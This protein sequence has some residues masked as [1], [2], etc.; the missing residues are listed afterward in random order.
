M[1]FMS[2]TTDRDAD[3][4]GGA[5][6]NAEPFGLDLGPPPA[7][8]AGFALHGHVEQYD[9][10]PDE[11]TIFPH[12][13]SAELPRTTAWVTAEEGSYCSLENSR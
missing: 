4:T 3:S 1:L 10:A 5:S 2:D 7:S 13:A 11:C 9:D 8:D 6:R 12:T